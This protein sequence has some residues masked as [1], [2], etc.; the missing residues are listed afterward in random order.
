VRHQRMLN[1]R[2]G[3]LSVCSSFDDLSSRPRTSVRPRDLRFEPRSG[4]AT[5]ATLASGQRR[6]AVIISEPASAGGTPAVNEREQK[7]SRRVMTTQRLKTE[8]YSDLPTRSLLSA[9]ASDTASVPA[10]HRTLSTTRQ[11]CAP[12]PRDTA[13][14]SANPPS[15]A[16][17]ALR[18]VPST[19]N[20]DRTQ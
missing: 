3:L 11:C 5:R 1:R 12:C 18:R 13:P 14:A 4:G 2:A 15:L 16:G 8:C 17:A 6:R 7:F 19:R 9:P 20:P 10:V